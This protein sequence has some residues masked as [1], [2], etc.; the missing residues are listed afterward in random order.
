ALDTPLAEAGLSPRALSWFTGE[1]FTTVE[2]VVVLDSLRISRI[3][4]IAKST[5]EEVRARAKQW[6]EMFPSTVAAARRTESKVP[7]LEDIAAVLVN[8][9]KKRKSTVH[10]SVLDLILARGAKR[11]D[12]F[13]PQVALGAMLNAGTPT[14]N[15]AL[16]DIQEEWLADEQ[17]GPA[18]AALTT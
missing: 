13:A 7:R 10:R 8:G 16:L 2:D 3:P 5:R 4:G 17:A 14:V 9:L 18:L 11:V 1:G 12:A 6:R 15:Q